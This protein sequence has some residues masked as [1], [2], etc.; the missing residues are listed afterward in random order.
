MLCIREGLCLKCHAEIGRFNTGQAEGVVQRTR[1]AVSDVCTRKRSSYA[2]ALE[3]RA[4]MSS[5]DDLC[6]GRGHTHVG[7]YFKY[8]IEE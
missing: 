2:D 8:F 6:R 5:V 7:K 1:I 4:G 3:G